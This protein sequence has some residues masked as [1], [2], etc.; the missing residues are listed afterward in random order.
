M[1]ILVLNTGSSSVKFELFQVK[2]D[3]PLQTVASG[4]VE[5]I[6]EAHHHA[7]VALYNGKQTSDLGPGISSSHEAALNGITTFLQDNDLL[8]DLRAVG[9]R[10]VHGG[11]TFTAPT[12]LDDDVIAQLAALSPLAPLHNPP[13][14]EGISIARG[15]WADVPHV[16]VFDTA[17]HTT[18]APQ[19]FRYA[20]PQ[21]WYADHGVRRYGFHGTSHAYVAAR[22]AEAVGRP[23]DEL[24]LITL[25][26]GNGAS[27]C[28]IDRGKSVGTSM[29][30]SPLEG[31]VM[32]T[33][34]GDLDPAVV[35]HMIRA[36]MEP[37][38]VEQALNKQSGLMGL[39]GD[40][41]L[42]RVQEA[43]DDGDT[44]ARLPLE[45]MAHLLRKY[46]C[47][48]LAVLGGL[49]AVVFTAGIGQHSPT[50]RRAVIQPLG[51]LG[52]RLDERVNDNAD[53]E[54]GPVIISPTGATPAV[55]VIATD[56]ERQIALDVRRLLD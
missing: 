45:V 42:R 56:E 38:Q 36:G 53:A 54:H 43:A 51:H 29:G 8:S 15:L 48:Y 17:F 32:G 52:L 35:F 55:L 12:V 5:G 2:A 34:S 21:D 16:A 49:D 14:L 6:G 10:V 3:D 37:D 30:L 50:V 46:I 19:A 24:K 22:A 31:L 44:D 26:L 11:E 9:H 20:V 40:N 1:S 33:R 27:A 18:L 4:L 13:A 25:H 39:A 23:L 47:S 28:A 7:K 41:D